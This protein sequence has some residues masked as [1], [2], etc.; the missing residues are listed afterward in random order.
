MNLSKYYKATI[1]PNFRNKPKIQKNRLNE[2]K[3]C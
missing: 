2:K 1:M 3:N